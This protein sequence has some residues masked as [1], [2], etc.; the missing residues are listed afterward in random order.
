VCAPQPATP[1]QTIF[2]AERLLGARFGN[3]GI[4]PDVHVL[5]QVVAPFLHLA[6]THL[7]TLARR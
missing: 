6:A 7:R 3:G 5:R 4:D 1:P 2:S